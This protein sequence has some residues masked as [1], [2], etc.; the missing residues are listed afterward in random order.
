MIADEHECLMSLLFDR[1]D[2]RIVNLKFFRGP[3]EQLS[4][5]DLCRS[6]REVIEDT[7][8]HERT[9]RDAPPRSRVA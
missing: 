5:D 3:T 2:R 9:R 7:W 1:D 6:V 4:M 8:A